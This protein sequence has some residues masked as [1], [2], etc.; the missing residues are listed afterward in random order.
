[1][2]KAGDFDS[3]LS[4]I[5]PSQTTINE[6]SRLHTNLRDHLEKHQSYKVVCKA[7]YL[8]GSYAKCTFIRPKTETEGCDI[9]II[10]ETSHGIDDDPKTVLNELKD[11]I[12]DR[13]VYKDVTLQDHSV[14]IDLTNF[15]IDVVPL[16]SNEADTLFIGSKS[17]GTWTE[18][19]PK[20]HKTWSTK[21]NQDFENNYKPLVK[22]FKWWR[23]EHCPSTSRYPKGITLEK[24]I[25]DCLP[26]T[27]LG[28]EDR[29]IQTMENISAAYEDSIESGSV[30]F[31]EDPALPENDLAKKHTASDFADF[32]AKLDEHLSLLVDKGT[33]NATWK[34]ILGSNFPSGDKSL[35]EANDSYER[36]IVFSA[37][38]KEKLCY[39]MAAKKPS[40]IITAEAMFP[41]GTKTIIENDGIALPKESSIVYRVFHRPVKGNLKFLW[42]I[43]NTGEEA[44]AVCPRGEFESPNYG[45][46]GRSETTAYK[47]K[48]FVQCFIIKS[49][50]CIMYSR[51]FY[52]NVR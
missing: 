43:T 44:L 48:H 49:G 52:I 2:A 36:Q 45:R 28:I 17:E 46:S 19:N 39:P 41:D 13:A 11:A 12:E 35:S 22:I 25:A 30:P 29:I 50:N 20:E 14:G 31:I 24:I 33:G 47:G 9:D 15:H 16:A 37:P 3:F 18:T 21:T 4:D 23:R 40:A 42:Q 51:P 38:H 1:M 7:T 27:G 26:D 10:V 8:S 32:K 6:A 5:N 34:Q